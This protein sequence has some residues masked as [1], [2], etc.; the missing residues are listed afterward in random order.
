MNK[1]IAA[2]CLALALCLSL[3]PAAAFAESRTGGN[4]KAVTDIF[5]DVPPGCWYVD[6][7]QTAYDNGIVSGVTATTFVPDLP[8]GSLTH[9]QILVMVAQLRSRLE[10]DG[11]D[12]L[13]HKDDALEWPRPYLDYCKDKGITDDRYDKVL[14]EAVTRSEMAYYFGNALPGK[15][16]KDK[17]TVSFPDIAGD[18][19]E[20]E[21]LRLAKAGIVG[22]RPGGSYAPDDLVSRAESTVFIANLLEAM[23]TGELPPQP[24]PVTE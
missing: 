4:G 19:Y 3:I 2:L 15:C 13:A 11:Y 23:K 6:F 24:G 9:G 10:G 5:T 17:V 20:T 7:L 22:G 16:Y 21:I 1:R 8:A 14:G 12:F 18:P